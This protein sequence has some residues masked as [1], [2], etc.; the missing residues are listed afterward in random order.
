M[1]YINLN[2]I[3]LLK[4]REEAIDNHDMLYEMFEEASATQALDFLS[5]RY[6]RDTHSAIFPTDYD[7]DEAL[8]VVN[9]YFDNLDVED[10]IYTSY[11]A[12]A[13]D[14]HT[15]PHRGADDGT[16]DYA[17]TYVIAILC[18]LQEHMRSL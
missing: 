16:Y 7:F 9:E 5:I 1:N 8:E 17:G 12:K 6:D 3:E 2:E 11:R 14:E 4:L 15:A 18:V 10:Y 13:Y